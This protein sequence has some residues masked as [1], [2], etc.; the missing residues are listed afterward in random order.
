[1]N[2]P[3][4]MNQMIVFVTQLEKL[5]DESKLVKKAHSMSLEL[6]EA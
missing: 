3:F 1:M 2:D 6:N 4:K 5:F